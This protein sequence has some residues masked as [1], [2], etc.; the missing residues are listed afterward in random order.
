MDMDNVGAMRNSIS[1]LST[2]LTQRQFWECRYSFHGASQNPKCIPT[3][4]QFIREKYSP[5]KLVKIWPDS[6]LSKPSHTPNF[7]ANKPG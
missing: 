5:A 2:T 3:W 1:E 4:F 7:R 6:Y